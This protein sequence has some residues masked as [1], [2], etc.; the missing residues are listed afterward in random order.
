MDTAL[1]TGTGDRGHGT[2]R[3]AEGSRA[4]S[5]EIK[6]EQTRVEKQQQHSILADFSAL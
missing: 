6:Q 1:L 4:G 3:R 5:I 2:G